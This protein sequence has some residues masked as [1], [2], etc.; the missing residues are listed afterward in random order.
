M[1]NLFLNFKKWI[2]GFSALANQDA[3][4]KECLNL[5][6]SSLLRSCFDR[7]EDYY[8]NWTNAN[9]HNY[10]LRAGYFSKNF[11]SQFNRVSE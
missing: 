2:T 8:K 4:S 7:K 3:Y 9:E 1:V 6:S 5:I 11:V 10:P